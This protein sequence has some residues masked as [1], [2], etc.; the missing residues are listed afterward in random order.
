M[1]DQLKEERLS[2]TDLNRVFD[3]LKQ[4]GF[5]PLMSG[6]EFVKGRK[7][8]FISAFGFTWQDNRYVEH[9][10]TAYEI[11]QRIKK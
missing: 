2:D 1:N 7:K 10:L 3:V 8:V 6:Q 5:E 11:L 9:D 4:Y